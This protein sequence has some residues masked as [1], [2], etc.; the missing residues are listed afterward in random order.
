MERGGA[1]AVG[2]PF[3][4]K[5]GGLNL[6][7]HLSREGRGSL[8][9]CSLW[10]RTKSVARAKVVVM[11]WVEDTNLNRDGVDRSF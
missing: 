9:G 10:L 11:G 2:L 3:P 7:P 6:S 5:F 1:D 8:P 4:S